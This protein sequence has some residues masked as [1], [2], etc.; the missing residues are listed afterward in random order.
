[1]KN[2]VENQ[3]ELEADDELPNMSRRSFFKRTAAAGGAAILGGGAVL[4][5]SKASLQGSLNTPGI[6]VDENFKA[7]DQRDVMLCHATSYHLS[8]VRNPERGEQYARLHKKDF[9]FNRALQTFENRDHFDNN[10]P[11][12]GQAD[13][14]IGHA[15]WYPLVV[16]KSRAAAFT[17]PNTPMHSWSQADVHE[18][19][20]DWGS[21]KRAAD[22]IRSTGR[23][24]GAVRVGIAKFD[25]RFVYD[26]LYDVVEER[27]LSWEKDFPFKPK[28]VIVIATPMDYDNV[29][30]APSWTAEG[31][32][33][34]GYSD[35][36]KI[37]CQIAKFIRGCGYNAVGAGNDLASSVAYAIQ[38]GLGEGGRNGSVIV[39]GM[40]P[41]VRLCKVFT[42]IDFDDA[43]DQPRTWGITEFC[44]SCK[45]CADACPS[46][47]IS[48]DDDTSFAP[49]YEFSDEPDYTW[50]N[51]IGIKKFYSDA[52]K[53]FNFWMDNDTSCLN[54]VASCTFNEPDFWH[55]WMI[56]AV[57]PY[58][59]KFVHS[60][61][62]EGHPAFGY[63][64]QSRN[65]I[66]AKVEK[67]W[68]SGEDMRTNTSMKNNIGTAG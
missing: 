30:T 20:F 39:P 58:M 14:A 24:F 47:A 5:A 43:Y 32:T 59:P 37:A 65:P 53:C 9:N 56:M 54:C 35:M 27:T 8:Q 21:G 63:G 33:G 10:K 66:P 67:F 1:M 57:N 18:E 51:H 25:K 17:Q 44:K 3:Q 45:K 68:V 19:Q 7:K 28:S 4:G 23:L 40:G 50:N 52:K 62:A 38:A 2:Q 64:G 11:G 29:A 31:A 49:T 12:Y 61:M 34:N 48:Q 26:P 16:A 13:R 60:L 42:N 41:R 36:S 46:G 6:I 22:M 55:H 15:A